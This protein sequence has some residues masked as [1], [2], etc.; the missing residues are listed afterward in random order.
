VT[1]ILTVIQLLQFEP[2]IEYWLNSN[3]TYGVIF[4]QNQA[5]CFVVSGRDFIIDAFNTGGIQ[6]NGQVRWHFPALS[7][8]SFNIDSM[9][10]GSPGG[11]T[12]KHTVGQMETADR[13]RSPCMKQQMPSSATLGS[14]YRTSC[15]L[16]LKENFHLNSFRAPFLDQRCCK[17]S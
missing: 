6:G 7:F 16:T 14:R 17:F 8:M 4:I 1:Q 15:C 11:S 9:K 12:F 2:N 10:H 3:N 5:S 13:S